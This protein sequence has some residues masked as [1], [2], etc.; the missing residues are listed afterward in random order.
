MSILVRCSLLAILCVLVGCAGNDLRQR[1][2]SE[3]W[4]HQVEKDRDF[5]ERKQ[6]L[7][8]DEEIVLMG[9]KKKARAAVQMDEGGKPRLNIKGT[10]GV[11]ADLDLGGSPEAALKY[12][13][14]WDFARPPRRK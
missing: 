7:R 3:S 4:L 10:K 6:R 5:Q 8:G 11:S 2:F 1:P 12:K 9:D 14:E 13:H